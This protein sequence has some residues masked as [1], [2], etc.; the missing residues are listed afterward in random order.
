ML[1]YRLV[2]GVIA[3]C[4]ALAGLA[5]GQDPELRPAVIVIT[6]LLIGGWA[7][8]VGLAERISHRATEARARAA[9]PDPAAQKRDMRGIGVLSLVMFG[10]LIGSYLGLYAHA[11]SVELRRAHFLRSEVFRTL[12]GCPTSAAGLTVLP[13]R[14]D[15]PRYEIVSAPDAFG[16][17]ILNSKNAAWLRI[18]PDAVRLESCHVG[19]TCPV[20]DIRKGAFPTREVT[21]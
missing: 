15:D 6:P 3:T 19:P 11:R 18:G 4:F 14:C 12:P 1:R 21:P 2:F 20:Q 7:L 8:W 9:E 16:L 13:K 5:I 10:V 17:P